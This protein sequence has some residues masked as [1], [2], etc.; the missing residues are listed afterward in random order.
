MKMKIKNSDVEELAQFLLNMKLK[1]KEN[2]M[3]NKFIRHLQG[4]LK[5]MQDSHKELLTEYCEMDEN[6]AFKTVV[7]DGKSFY[8]IENVTDFQREFEKLMEE[9]FYLPSDEGNR[10][11][12]VTLKDLVLNSEEEFSGKEALKYEAYCEIFENEYDYT[13]L[14]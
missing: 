4:H 14:G 2:R 13:I 11:M 3:R 7:K 10:E 9:F 1:G 5:E 12:I 8:D 6:G